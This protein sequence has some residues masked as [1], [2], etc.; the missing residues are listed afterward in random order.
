MFYLVFVINAL[1]D[2]EL[3]HYVCFCVYPSCNLKGT[4]RDKE[5]REIGRGK[6]KSV[7]RDRQLQYTENV[8]ACVYNAAIHVQILSKKQDSCIKQK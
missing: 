4:E 6:V 5:R 1:R 2:S 3:A 8:S 7:E